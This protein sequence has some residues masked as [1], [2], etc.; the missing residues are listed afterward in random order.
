LQEL[1]NQTTIKM[2]AFKSLLT[3]S[4]ALLSLHPYPENNDG[5]HLSIKKCNDENSSAY[6]KLDL[7][8][9]EKIGNVF[10][11]TISFKGEG[12]T[13]VVHR[14]GGTG[15]Y[16]VVDPNPDKPAFTGVFR[17]DGRPEISNKV[18]ISEHGKVCRYD[19]KEITNTDGSGVLFNSFIWGTPPADLHPGDTWTVNIAQPW[20]LGGPG[21]QTVSVME[22]DPANHTIRLKREGKGSGFFD[23]DM[24]QLMVTTKDGKTVKMDITPGDSHWTGYTTFKNGLVI[25]DELVVTRPVTLTSDGLKFTASQREYI[26]LNE[27]PANSL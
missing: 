27:M 6:F 22:A 24:H 12:F 18:E 10:S 1:F 19:G 7:K 21:L 20:E 14:V 23:N 13:E 15:I 2:N 4:V 3:L 8:K 25:S 17:Y 16:T 9:D 26:L 11:R 5:S